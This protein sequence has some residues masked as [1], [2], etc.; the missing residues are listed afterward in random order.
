MSSEKQSCWSCQY[1]QL[2]GSV[3]PCGCKW[4]LEHGKGDSVRDVPGAVA[5]QGCKLWKPK[6][7]A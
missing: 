2:G 6:P 7:T 3:F 5:D 1:C 4:F